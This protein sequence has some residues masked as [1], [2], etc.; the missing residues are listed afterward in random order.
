MAHSPVEKEWSLG[1][2]TF[3]ETPDHGSQH[4]VAS[5]FIPSGHPIPSRDHGVIERTGSINILS[6]PSRVNLRARIV[7]E[8]RTLRS[9]SLSSSPTNSAQYSVIVF[10]SQIHKKVASTQEPNKMLLVFFIL[11]RKPLFSVFI[12]DHIASSLKPSMA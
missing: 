2:E 4:V 1:L 10:M 6:G 12:A 5:P 11:F 9:A 7:G 3:S 8:F